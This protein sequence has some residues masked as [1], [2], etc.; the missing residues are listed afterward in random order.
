MSLFRIH[1]T[2]SH[3]ALMRQPLSQIV[4]SIHLEIQVNYVSNGTTCII[5]N[6]WSYELLLH[7]SKLH[8]LLDDALERLNW[9]TVTGPFSLRTSISRKWHLDQGDLS[10]P[11]VLDTEMDVCRFM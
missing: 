11:S 3:A 10:N 7:M 8:L 6:T 9:F 4:G 2:T 5:L 1:H